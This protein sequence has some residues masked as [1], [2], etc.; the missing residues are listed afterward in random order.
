M[1]IKIEGGNPI[2]HPIAD[3]NLKYLFPNTSFPSPLAPSNV[4]PFGYGVYE[5]SAAPEVG[6]WQ[7]VVEVTPVK[8]AAGVWVQTWEVQPLTPE[9]RRGKE[10]SM[11]QTNK[12]NAAS[13]LTQ[14]DWSVLPDV[15]LQNKAEWESYREALR[16][17][18]RNPPIEV[19]SWPVKPPE[20]WND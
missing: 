16:V 5:Q 18:A 10:A 17:I 2:G 3:E 7:K 6:T 11:K 13:F 20:T 15:S 14:S 19:T 8:N 12:V 4:E 1:L 9:E